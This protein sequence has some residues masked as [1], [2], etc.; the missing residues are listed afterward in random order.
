MRRL[1]VLLAA[2]TALV[3]MSLP[4]QAHRQVV[5]DPNDTSGKLDI[6]RA[7]LSHRGSGQDT[8]LHFRSGMFEEFR[9]RALRGGRGS[10]VFQV[11]RSPESSWR[12]EI[13]RRNNGNLVANLAMCIEAQ[14][15]DFQDSKS[16]PVTRPTDKSV[17]VKIPK[18]DLQGV[19]NTV[20][21]LNN[22]AFG[23][24][25]NGNCFFDRAPN[26]GL[27]NHQL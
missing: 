21:W 7:V 8:M 5:A 4:A 27:A 2:C 24:G 12:I 15:C 22:T 10:I 26:S 14:G 6:K 16:Y 9:N 25:C 19:A 17:K 11:R 1:L 18:A 20:R 23:R 3:A 13:T